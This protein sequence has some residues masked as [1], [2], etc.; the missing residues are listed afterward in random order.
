[1]MGLGG[2]SMG[3]GNVPGWVLGF[4]TPNLCQE[5]EEGGKKPTALYA[6]FLQPCSKRS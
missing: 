2:Q 6:T 1:M 3:L 4:V 5:M